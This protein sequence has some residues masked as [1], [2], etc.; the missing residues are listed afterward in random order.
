MAVL[1]DKDAFEPSLKKVAVSFV[2]FVKKLGIDTVK[3]PHA[4][5][6]VAIGCFDQKMI[7]V[8]HE[9]VG[10]AQPIITFIDVLKNV[11]EVLAILIVLEDRFLL[12]AT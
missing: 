8:G 3:L 9:A 7:M 1:L 2:S 12:V 11:K 5:G 4:K 10:V 6:E